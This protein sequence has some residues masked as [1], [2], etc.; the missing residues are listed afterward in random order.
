MDYTQASNWGLKQPR[1]RR[2]GVSALNMKN[3][4]RDFKNPRFNFFKTKILLY[5]LMQT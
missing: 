3:E 4:I 2:V 5:M 1:T